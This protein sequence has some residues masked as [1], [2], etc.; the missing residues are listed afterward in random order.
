V[1]RLGVVP[2]LNVAPLVHGLDRDPR[3]TLQAVVPSQL[4]GLL[5]EGHVDLATIPSIEYADDWRIVPGLAIASRGPVRSVCLFHRVPLPR[6]RRVALDASSRTSVALL[7]LLLAERGLTPT[8]VTRP[9]GPAMLEEA[10]AALVIGDPCLAWEDDTE[11]LDLGAEWTALTGQAFVWAVWAGPAG[12]VRPEHVAALQEA[13]RRGRQAIP[14][15]A[16][17]YNLRQAAAAVSG[18]GGV[19]LL[20]EQAARNE[21]YLRDNMVHALDEAGLAGLREFH[22]RAHAAGLVPRVPELRFHGDS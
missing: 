13:M 10:E 21:A 18:R 4:P 7:K 2:Y 19:A 15:I 1:V 22:R 16:A 8:F 12:P 6:V 11:R 20:T 5:R 9:P 17:G 3:F 14:A